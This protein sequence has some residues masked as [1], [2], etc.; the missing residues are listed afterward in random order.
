MG[1]G[2]SNVRKTNKNEMIVHSP[3]CCLHSAFMAQWIEKNVNK[4]IQLLKVDWRI[5]TYLMFNTT[6]DML[7]EQ[8]S[9]ILLNI[10]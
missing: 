6:I 5:W 7:V 10:T 8:N 1:R 9:G 3:Q 2:Q 4:A